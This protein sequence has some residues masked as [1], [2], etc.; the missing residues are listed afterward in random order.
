MKDNEK[1]II[2]KMHLLTYK[3]PS[4]KDYI[5]PRVMV[6]DK[7]PSSKQSRDNSIKSMKLSCNTTTTRKTSAPIITLD[8]KNLKEGLSAIINFIII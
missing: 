8:I 6:M 2:A 5:S 1:Q 4:K 3:T 7:N